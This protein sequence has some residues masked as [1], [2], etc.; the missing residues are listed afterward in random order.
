MNDEPMRIDAAIT[1]TN[2][3]STLYFVHADKRLERFS[4]DR[5]HRLVFTSN[6]NLGIYARVMDASLAL[7]LDL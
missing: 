7:R 6:G 2:G 4:A 5:H 3:S 1:A